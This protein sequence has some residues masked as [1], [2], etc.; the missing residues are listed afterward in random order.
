M[1]ARIRRWLIALALPLRVYLGMLF[2]LAS[3]NDIAAPHDFAVIIATYDILPL[4]WI[5]ALA[6]LLPWVEL[7]FGLTLIV[8]FWTRAA[9]LAVI[10]M[11][12]MFIV[13]LA[14]ALAKDLQVSCGC[15]A[16]QDAVEKI[17][18]ATLVRDLLW[19]AAASFVLIVDDGRFGLDRFARFSRAEERA[20]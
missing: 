1:S 20:A 16:A 6:L 14:L 11:M 3:L 13:A 19:L 18:A 17:T 12:I 5:N 2:I 8:G 7:V 15:F 9:A 10:G 4:S